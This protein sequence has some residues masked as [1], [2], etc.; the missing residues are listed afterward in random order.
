M[1]VA[2]SVGEAAGR[3]ARSCGAVDDISR[4]RYAS[5]FIKEKSA[6]FSRMSIFRIRDLLLHV[7]SHYSDYTHISPI[8]LADVGSQPTVVATVDSVELKT[9]R[10]RFQI[11]EVYVTDDTGIMKLVFFRQPWVAKQ[12]KPGDV[13]SASGKVS[14]AYGFKQMTPSYWEHLE[15]SDRSA[16]M[17]RIL[18]SYPVAEGIGVGWMRRLI[19]AAL[20]DEGD[21]CD[22]LP[23]SFV[24]MHKLPTLGRALRDVHFPISLA[25]AELARRRLAYDELICLQLALLTRQRIDFG[26]ATAFSHIVDGPHLRSLRGA[27]PFSLTDEQQ[28][29]SDE[30]LSDM[31]SP[32]AMNRLLLGDVG[33]GKTVVAALAIA[34][35]AD[36]GTQA[37]M[38]APTSVLASQYAEKVG[39]LLEKANIRWALI[40]GSTPP[41]QRAHIGEEISTGVCT[42]VFG[43]TALLADDIVFKQLSLVVVDEQQ[44]FGVDQRAALRHKGP[45]ADLL[46]M[47]AT[48]IPRTLALS[49]YGDME[50]SRIRHRPF[51]GA[52]VKTATLTPENIDIA[53]GG[54]KQI[55]AAG[56]QAYVV[57]PLVDDSDEGEEL[58]DVPAALGTGTSQL[59]S[60]ASMAQQVACWLPHASVATLTGKMS[61]AQKDAVMEGFR[62]KKIQV[63]VC[64]TVIEV[65]VDV[66]NAT[67]ML[68]FDA[69]RF[70]LATLHQLRGR[71]G[72]GEIAGKVWLVCAARKGTTARRRLDALESTS[73]G[74][75]LAELD[76][77]LR[78]EG[79]VLG[80]RQHGGVSLHISDLASDADLVQWAH[81]DALSISKVD[82]DLSSALYRPLAFEVRDRFGAYFE[83]VDP[84]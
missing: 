45:G 48:P 59:H 46:A 56:E 60:V 77:H 20:T 14:F 25:A 7:P 82:P 51:P 1:G 53:I 65:G 71:V 19:S 22:F 9:P 44:R 4:L 34:A 61:A 69:D 24:A 32:R 37:A 52:G 63:L 17:A 21:V 70:G 29:A 2:A 5:R 28:Q 83:E 39:P 26:G 68:I 66:P 76:L 64:T 58:D 74:F 50:C 6:P 72:R 54:L 78:R 62:S 11:V 41:A 3:V 42:V 10:P 8:A 13:I 43:T 55:L 12:L 31:A 33:T 79:E 73:D 84:A 49:I 16:Q 40:M 67:A 57:C 18:P 30:V 36:T 75:V 23:A 47:T 81:A 38:M 15:S 35:V 27:L 80:Y